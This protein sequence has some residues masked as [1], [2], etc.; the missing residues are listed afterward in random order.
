MSNIFNIHLHSFG[1]SA[2]RPNSLHKIINLRNLPSPP[3]RLCKL[4]TGLDARFQ[5]E[6]WHLKIVEEKYQSVLAD[7]STMFI[8]HNPLHIGIMCEHGIHRSVAFVQRLEKELT[9]ALLDTCPSA[10]INI[11]VTHHHL[12]KK[13]RGKEKKNRR[14]HKHALLIDNSELKI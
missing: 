8:N 1:Y 2:C 6:F 14:F 12:Y 13:T 11:L 3:S 5:K 10:F 9:H 4:Y 7:L